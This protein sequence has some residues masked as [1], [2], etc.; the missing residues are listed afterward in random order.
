MK[1][2]QSDTTESFTWDEAIFTASLPT[3][4]HWTA[5]RPQKGWHFKQLTC[6]T[7]ESTLL[8]VALKLPDV[9]N[10]RKGPQTVRPL[11]ALWAKE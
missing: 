11:S 7:T 4:Q 8:R 2:S 10:N 1:E 3:C 6:P 9:S 5:E